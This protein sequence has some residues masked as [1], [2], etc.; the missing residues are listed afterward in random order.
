MV[1][2]NRRQSRDLNNGLNIAE[3]ANQ[4]AW[5]KYVISH[6]HATVYHRY[7]WKS[8][9]EQTYGHKTF[10]MAAQKAGGSIGGVLPLVQLKHFLLGN[11]L[12]SIPFFDTGGILADDEVAERALLDAALKLAAELRVNT[13]ELRHTHPINEFVA[14]QSEIPFG[15]CR[16]RMNKVLMHLDLPGSSDVLMKSFKSKL[17]SQIRKPMKE[18][19]RVNI[20]GEKLLHDFYDVFLVNMR[21]LGSPVHSILLM[22]NVLREFK[23]SARI[24]LVYKDGQPLACSLT[25][26][27]KET[28]FNP[29]AS[30]L[31]T[32]SRL[33]PNMLLY[34][35]ML[36]YAADSGFKRF[37]FG[38]S[39]PGEGTYRFKSQW[40]A[41]P[42]PLRWHIFCLRERKASHHGEGP[43]KLGNFIGCWK[44]LP[45]FITR[46]IGPLIRK[47]I[48][49]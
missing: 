33:S 49:L 44:R 38:R 43:E 31:R 39:T 15:A 29:W 42:Q 1:N 47:H 27:F 35:S 13:L 34:W 37:D 16:T 18:G 17:R 22:R 7:G 19:L 2:T 48:G 30:S 21:D 25:I 10:Y 8:V 40:G 6:R 26:G 20:G 12:I 14:S 24:F 28:L 5:D 32:F 9:I 36:A 11:A 3:C 23:N 4:K 46:L 45:V 41:H